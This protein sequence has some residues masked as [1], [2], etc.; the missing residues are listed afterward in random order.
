MS[1]AL[2]HAAGE[3]DLEIPFLEMGANSLM[4]M[5]VQKT[6]EGEYGISIT[7]GQF[8]EELTNIKALVH[9]IDNQLQ[10]RAENEEA[11]SAPLQS[12]GDT[13]RNLPVSNGNGSAQSDKE[14]TGARSFR[15]SF[16]SLNNQDLRGDEGELEAIFASQI[17]LTSQAM[18][19]LVERQLEFLSQ[20]GLAKG[21]HPSR[22]VESA[23][24]PS[25]AVDPGSRTSPDPS[26]PPVARSTSRGGLQPQK[27]LTPL[28]IRAR[29]LS[30]TQQS[31]L[32]KLIKE[33]NAR[34]GKSKEYTQRY[35]GVLADSRAG[36][37]FRFSTKEMLYPLVANRASG[38][39]VWDLDGNEYIDITMGQG[40]S[41][42]GHHP[43]FIE[44]AI[45]E[46][47]SE[48]VEL[49]PRPHNVGEV[50]ELICE[51]TGFD[52]VTFTNSGTEAVMAALR[53]ARA[54]TGR[55][56]I[57]MFEGAY[58]GHADSVMGL[59]VERDGQL[60][61]LPVSP[62]TPQGAVDDLWILPYDEES[63][64]EFIRRNGSSIAAVFVEPVQSR[65]PRI[66]PREFLHDLRKLTSEAGAL[67]VFD[68]MITGF[69]CHP[70]GAQAHFGVKADL[71]TYG[72]V[73]G[74]GMPIG[75]VAGKKEWMDPIDGGTWQYGDTS[76][77]E[78]NRVV[79]GGTFCQHPLAM[80]STLATLR[81]F[82]EKGPGLQEELNERTWRLAEELNEWFD[83]EEVP[84]RVIWFGSLFRFE[85]STNLELLF[86]HMNLRGI[87]VWEWRNCF[88]S[89]AHSDED[90]DRIIE[91]VRESVIAMREGGF[92]PPKGDPGQNSTHTLKTGITTN[93]N[94]AAQSIETKNSAQTDDYPLNRAQHQLA[95]LARISAGGS[96][97]YHVNA[98]LSL[99][100]E[101]DRQ[102]LSDSVD[103]VV[104]RHESLRSVIIG[105]RQKVLP[106]ETGLLQVMDLSS[107]KDP[108]AACREWLHQQ[109]GT[110][111][112]LEKGPLFGV[113]LLKI[114]PQEYR[115]VLKGHHIILD[116][117][118]MNLIIREI[119]EGYC[120]GVSG[121]S[122]DLPDPMQYREYLAWQQ[123]AA[124]EEQK[125]YW[126]EK[127]SD[128]VPGL[129][130]PADQPEP[131]V[132]S[133]SGGRIS[134]KIDPGLFTS[135]RSFSKTHGVT[136]FMTLFSLYTLWL[137]RLSGHEEL[138]VG[139]P[140]AGR[141]V[142][143]ADCL[144]GYCTHLLPILSRVKWDESFA[145]YLKRMRG[146]LL[147]GYQHQD[148]PFSR[149]MENLDL[150]RKGLQ[151]PWIQAL[152]NL[153]RP[154]EIPSFSGLDVSWQSQSIAH[155]AFD[156][157][158]NLTEVGEEIVLE[159]DF[160]RDRFFSS[161]IEQ[162]VDCFMTLAGEVISRPER[163]LAAQPLMSGELRQKWLVEWNQTEHPYESDE[164]VSRLFEAQA[165]KNSKQTALAWEGGE[166]TYAGLNRE[167]NRLARFL[168]KKSGSPGQVVAIHLKRS[169][170]LIIGILGALKSGMSYLPLDPDSPAERLNFMLSDAKPGILLTETGLSGSLILPEGTEQVMVEDDENPFK[171]YSNKNLPDCPAL[172]D[173]AYILYTSG[174]TGKPKG[175]MIRHRGLLNYLTWAVDFYKTESGSGSPL[176]SSI[177]FDATLTSLFTPLLSGRILHLL[178][179]EGNEI[180]HIVSF[181]TMDED[182]S[183][184]RDWSLI[185]LTPSHLELLNE[186]IPDHKKAGIARTLVLGGEQLTGRAI[187]PWRRSAPDMRIVNEY[188]P[189]ETVV[190]CAVYEEKRTDIP[191]GSI[192]VGRPIWNTQLY[193]LD[194]N[195]YPVPPGAEGELYI[196]GDGVAMGYLNR[197]D[198]D[199]AR[200]IDIRQTGLAD[201]PETLPPGKL[202]RTGDRVRLLADGNLIFLGRY[203]HQIKLRGY[204][205]EPGEIE[206]ALLEHPAVQEAVVILQ[207]NRQPPCLVA[208]IVSK[209]GTEI[210][211]DS[212]RSAL[213]ERIPAH[214]IPSHFVGLKKIPLTQNGKVDVKS[215]PDISLSGIG[216]S[217]VL[218]PRSSSERKVAAI[219]CELLEMEMVGVEE[220][221]FDIGGH[222][223]L[224]LP[225]RDQLSKAFNCEVAPAD[226][227]KYPTISAMAKFLAPVAGGSL[228]GDKDLPASGRKPRASGKRKQ[229]K[230]RS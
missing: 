91:V 213:G 102:T 22:G 31:H 151:G 57:V 71:A 51:M 193:L 128:P 2:P 202:Y 138:M 182:E 146:V 190:G 166:L 82:K 60:T 154:G 224:V 65:N 41:L 67:L 45:S 36:I 21:S 204:R 122:L 172:D 229:S 194:Q 66:Q 50:A 15:N 160:N 177:G 120:S 72:K 215:L 98:L 32:E 144:V 62:G 85:F 88:L 19:E 165:K 155:S 228:D 125:R 210:D 187:E 111:M 135:I 123:S 108:D 171:S 173:L 220:N 134:R 103:R 192:P 199:E 218:T 75:V 191:D 196:G 20:A 227:F 33:Y 115:L 127:L 169:P 211:R 9:Y 161:T 80:T 7:I 86:Y 183:E 197:E 54:A 48:S 70:A 24:K 97:A 40:V 59:P 87:F 5:D 141:S 69:R 104:G 77:P 222:S 56:K 188:G 106:A 180:E 84:I 96:M 225:M 11:A 34:T 13:D 30:S 89:T 94:T 195:G 186:M 219:W 61:T 185:K 79:F 207:E 140:V 12:T 142:K 100:G 114:G 206:T 76:Y 93:E 4:L 38:S 8:F 184:S 203:D 121:T 42:F 92:I 119:A 35:R 181:L 73:I 200:F 168:K 18:N 118:S 189:T 208:Y 1:Q 126:L 176:H 143:G 230:R 136:H 209:T 163:S 170:Q 68:E 221:F 153:D 55:S 205:I 113:H 217:P 17:R 159:C 46:E 53:L 137:H 58:H 174:S 90:I 63:S 178:P 131:A 14:D 175:T 167:A 117:L 158:F 124:F 29:G 130:L 3:N 226:V 44:K 52:R 6:I 132:K 43:A 105:D 26:T 101:V 212:L 216:K 39:R 23:G 16:Q 201:G 10:R 179:T 147:D 149:L 198:L 157:V 64:L 107:E 129:E 83:T 139:M 156:L 109:A 145:D 214:M 99:S 74:G 112:D 49:G 223:L 148:Y 164:P 152:F 162:F 47:G 27:I 150:H 78:V 116:G 37:G 81:H 25:S 28:E 133:Y 110:P 95:T